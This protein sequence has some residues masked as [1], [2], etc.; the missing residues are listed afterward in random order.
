MRVRLAPEGW[1]SHF[2]KEMTKE[3]K[4]IKNHEGLDIC[5]DEYNAEEQS[6]NVK[7]SAKRSAWAGRK[8]SLAALVTI[9]SDCCSGMQPTR[10][11][12]RG[13]APPVIEQSS[14]I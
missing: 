4:R 11:S 5:E 14:T 10:P 13:W 2:L 9:H 12:I 3:A 1:T 6:Q 8:L 7:E